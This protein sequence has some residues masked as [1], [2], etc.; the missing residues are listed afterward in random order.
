MTTTPEPANINFVDDYLPALLA[1]AASL[2]SSQF[3]Q[4][5]VANGFTVSEWRVLAT[6]ADGKPMTVGRLV[7]I[8]VTKQPTITRVLDRMEEKGY[9][10]RLPYETDRRI[11]LVQIT[12]TGR[13]MVARLM[14]QAREHEMH[15]LEPFGQRRTEE[16][17]SILRGIIQLH[18]APAPETDVAIL[19]R[20][21]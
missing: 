11:T 6:L 9:V 18:R 5:V 3:H 8:T 17:K 14:P 12:K 21:S 13:A 19:N 15:A 16:L 20:E 2:L 4:I 1:Q 10:K 7:Q